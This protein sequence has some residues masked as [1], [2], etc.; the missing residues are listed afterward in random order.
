MTVVFICLLW[1]RVSLSS[2]DWPQTHNPTASASFVL[3]VPVCPTTP[4]QT[5]RFTRY[6]YTITVTCVNRHRTVPL[7]T[8]GLGQCLWGLS[9]LL[10]GELCLSFLRAVSHC[11]WELPGRHRHQAG[12]W[13]SLSLVK[14]QELGGRSLVYL[15]QSSWPPNFDHIYKTPSRWNGIFFFFFWRLQKGRDRHHRL[16]WICGLQKAGG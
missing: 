14:W 9:C 8:A 7:G 13:S 3:C 10:H 4:R 2:P 15:W 16:P 1:V 11:N 5:Y 6:F 12:T